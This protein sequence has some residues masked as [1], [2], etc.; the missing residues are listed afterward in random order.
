MALPR[1]FTPN[2][3]TLIEFLV[4]MAIMAIIFSM[5]L[6]FSLDSYRGYSFRSE[7]NL[8]ITVL[9]KARS[10]AIANVDQQPH[11]VHVDAAGKQYII[12]EGSA[13][14]AG[15]TTNINVPFVSSAVSHSSMNDVLFNQL[16]GSITTVPAA[17]HFADATH[18]SDISE[19]S[20][21]QISWTN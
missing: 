19:N 17:W 18:S 5:G 21:G 6:F 13:Y 2:G 16:D 1:T 14:A 7:R 4:A 8:A 3:F 20:E 10:Q 15:A 12:F 9:Q 11:G